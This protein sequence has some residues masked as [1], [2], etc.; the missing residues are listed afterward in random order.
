MGN[1]RAR[2]FWAGS[3]DPDKGE[4]SPRDCSS[5]SLKLP[6][7]LPRCVFRRTK[8]INDDL[9]PLLSSKNQIGVRTRSQTLRN[10]ARTAARLQRRR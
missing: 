9:R 1:V 3:A 10:K 2:A 4:L 8:A 6:P 5:Q 7:S